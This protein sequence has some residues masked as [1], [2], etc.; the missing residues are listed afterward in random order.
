MTSSRRPR[1]G[2]TRSAARGS[3]REGEAGASLSSL[4][5]LFLALSEC[6]KEPCEDFARDVA[7][8]A[9]HR[10]VVEGFR[11]LAL[12][13]DLEPLRLAGAPD[14]VLRTLKRAYYPLFVIPPRF[15][16]PVESVYKDWAGEDGFLAGNRDMIMGPPAADMLRRYEEA[17]I[18]F[19]PEMKDYP[20]HLAL[21][22]EYAGLLSAAGEAEALAEFASD[23]LDGWLDAF[24]VEVRERAAAPFYP[25]VAG[26]TAV[27]AQAVR[28]E[29]QNR[30]TAEGV[31]LRNA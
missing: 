31:E 9:L 19:P 4:G 30:A 13:A 1:S 12:A 25:A 16:L 20:D 15:V 3:R 6:F 24:A 26:A 21:L 22:L 18:A 2:R 10:T 14:E 27:L 29:R 5:D 7:S 11:A 28:S 17:G 23:H 8:G